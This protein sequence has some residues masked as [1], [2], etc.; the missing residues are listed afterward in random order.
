MGHVRNVSALILGSLI[1]SF[2]L[3]ANAEELPLRRIL[4]ST[5]GVGYFEHEATVKDNAI[6]SLD[7]RLDQVSDVLKSIVIFDA[8]GHLG[9]A[10]LAGKEPLTEVFRDLPFTL[11]DLSSPATLLRALRGANVRITVNASTFEGRIISVTEEM[12][13]LD[14]DRGTIV[15]HRLTLMTAMGLRQAIVEDATNIEIVDPI[16]RG[17]V[18]SA[19]AAIVQNNERERRTIGIRVEGQGERMVNVGYVVAAPLW[20]ATYRLVL[21][22]SM[23]KARVEGLALL[24]NMSGHDWLGVDLTVASGNPVTFRQALYD[25]YFVKR[26]EVP[27]EVFGRILPPVDVGAVSAESTENMALDSGLFSLRSRGPSMFSSIPPSGEEAPREVAAIEG[28]TDVTFHF[29]DPIDLMRGEAMLAPIIQREMQA[30]RVSVFRRDVDKTNPVASVRLMND[31]STSLPPGAVTVYEM[32]GS[33]GDVEYVGDA[34]LGALPVGE[35]RLLGYAADLKVRVDVEDKSA[36]LLTGATTE[37]GIL[38]VRRV[39]Q[40]QT[41][42]RIVGPANEARSMIIEHP[43]VTGFSLAAP[44]G[45]QLGD[46]P[47]HHR[48]AVEVPAGQTVTLDVTLER[49]IEQRISLVGMGAT[50]LGVFVL[51]PEIPAEVKEVLKRVMDLQRTLADRQQTL[52]ALETERTALVADQARLRANLAAVPAES[53]LRTRYLMALGETED[54]LTALDQAIAAGREAVK[55]A[56]DELEAFIAALSM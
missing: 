30:E 33:A 35:E 2:T 45:G 32:Q 56:K 39:E 50:D 40:R 42:Y 37:R 55:M 23:N 44:R 36:Q 10:T 14:Q 9:R 6:F 21:P 12:T 38:V 16:L 18:D 7:V 53:E 1:G 46:T 24:E 3:S 19:L 4:L 52:T 34:R 26:P 43:R 25:T 49:P 13:T 47:T 5:G 54:R 8:Q 22:N 20:K 29:P 48:I 41:K 15:R 27:V 17:Q 31:S 11:D 28:A 51:A